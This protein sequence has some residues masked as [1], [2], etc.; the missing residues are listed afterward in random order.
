MPVNV[1]TADMAHQLATFC[2]DAEATKRCRPNCTSATSLCDTACRRSCLSVRTVF[3]GLTTSKVRTT[4]LLMRGVWTRSLGDC[5]ARGHIRRSTAVRWIC[6]FTVQGALPKG[7]MRD[8]KLK[9]QAIP[10]WG[11]RSLQSESAATKLCTKGLLRMCSIMYAQLRHR[12]NLKM[13]CASL[14][15]PFLRK[16]KVRFCLSVSCEWVM[17][18]V[19]IS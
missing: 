12:Q 10:S 18:A 14:S 11:R 1:G 9:I 4:L 13:C 5:S 6:S 7:P 19:C 2:T 16:S 15:V 8:L 17:A 3:A